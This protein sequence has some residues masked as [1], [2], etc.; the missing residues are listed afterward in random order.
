[1][2]K[3]Y[4]EHETAGRVELDPARWSDKPT[5]CRQEEITV[6]V[7]N[8][9]HVL[10]RLRMAGIRIVCS[11]RFAPASA[12]DHH[13]YVV[14]RTTDDDRAIRVLESSFPGACGPTALG[15][16][17]QGV[18]GEWQTTNNTLRKEGTQA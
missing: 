15:S 9:P 6:R 13:A 8:E 7:K 16:A 18:G 12:A 3:A 5:A 17:P 10:E 2:I 1:M 4:V 14:F 11:C